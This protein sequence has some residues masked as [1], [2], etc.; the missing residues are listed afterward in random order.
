MP[1]DTTRASLATPASK[2]VDTRC[3]RIRA[4]HGTRLSNAFECKVK[5]VGRQNICATVAFAAQNGLRPQF[6]II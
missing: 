1:S 2:Q 3:A 6:S 5:P 4:A